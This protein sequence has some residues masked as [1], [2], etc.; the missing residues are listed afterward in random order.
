MGFLQSNG[1][2]A[3][4]ESCVGLNS[5]LLWHLTHTE[6]HAPDV[7]SGSENTFFF[8]SPYS[9]VLLPSSPALFFFFPSLIRFFIFSPFFPP[10][11]PKCSP[12]FFSLFHPPY[13]PYFF[14]LVFFFSS[15]FNLP[16]LFS[17]LPISPTFFSSHFNPIFP[18]P[19]FVSAI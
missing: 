4:K 9:V 11:Y 6:L 10:P 5:L 18:L 17:I 1:H 8:L 14:Y 12:S 19:F 13:I 3:P 16:S 15:I 2:C 7:Q